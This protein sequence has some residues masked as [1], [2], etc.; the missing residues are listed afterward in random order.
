MSDDLICKNIGIFFHDPKTSI[1]PPNN[2]GVLYL[3]RRDIYR[4][5]GYNTDTWKIERESILW[6]ATMTVLAGIDLLSKFYKGDDSTNEVGQRFKVFYEKYFDS[7]NA[8]NIYQLRNSMLHSFGLVSKTKKKIIWFMVSG[9][10]D[11]LIVQLSENHFKIDLLTLLDKFEESIEK[12]KKDLLKND[13]L[14]IKFECMF[15]LY[16]TVFIG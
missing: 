3:L 2:F 10:H 14:Q 11:P 15:K 1:Q 13:L 5:L 7:T 6:P 8:E 12:Y 4:C 9:S 16:G